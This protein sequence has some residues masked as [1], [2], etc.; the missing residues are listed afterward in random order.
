MNLAGKEKLAGTVGHAITN[1]LTKQTSSISL[2]CKEASTATTTKEATVDPHTG[3]AEAEHKTE[4]RASNRVKKIPATR[5]VIS[6]TMQAILVSYVPIIK[7]E[8]E[9][10][11]L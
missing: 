9:T 3:N 6:K 8:C 7:V 5:N 10:P 4:I 11:I 1:F 2:N